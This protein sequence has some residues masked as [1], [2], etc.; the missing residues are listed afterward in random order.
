M[1]QKNVRQLKGQNVQ[2]FTQGFRK[3]ALILGVDL[4]SQDIFLK[5]IGGL[6]IYL[7]NNILM[8]SPMNFDEACIQATHLEERGKNI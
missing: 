2:E 8:F 4:Q 3:R 1:N 6:H 5:Y 7:Q